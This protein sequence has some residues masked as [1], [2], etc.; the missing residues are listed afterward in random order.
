MNYQKVEFKLSAANNSQFPR[1]GI[2]QIAFAGKSNVGKSSVIN[3]VLQRKNLAYVGASPGKTIHINYFLVDHTAYLVDLPG[4]GY[5]KVS[6]SE[7]ERWGRLME[8]YFAAYDLLT[9]GILIVD[10]RHAPTQN[11]VVM[12]QWFQQTGCPFI[13]VANKLDKLKKREVEPNMQCIRETLSLSEDT[14]LIP[15]SAEKGTGRGELISYIEKAAKGE[16]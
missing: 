6:K 4:Y 14:V 1:D 8:S 13:V 2:P 10:A 3:R 5:A 15:F 11:D 9:L 12:A 7:K 16:L